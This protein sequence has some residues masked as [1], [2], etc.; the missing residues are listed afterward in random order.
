MVRKIDVRLHKEYYDV[1]TQFG[2]L[3]EVVD[4][5]IN[6]IEAGTINIDELP[7]CPDLSGTHK[8]IVTIDNPFYDDLVQIYGSHSNKISM[9]RILYYVVDNELYLQF[10]WKQ[11]RLHIEQSKQD[12]RID[13]ILYEL[14]KAINAERDANSLKILLHAYSIIQSLK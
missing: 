3:N 2:T 9:R 14:S 5:V 10:R 13:N 8:Y 7:R 4:K 12:K 11:M 1:L 6:E